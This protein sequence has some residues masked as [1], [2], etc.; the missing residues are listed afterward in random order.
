MF[1]IGIL[2]PGKD[3]FMLNQGL[4]LQQTQLSFEFELWIKSD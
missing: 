3:C 2:I 4:E 1:N